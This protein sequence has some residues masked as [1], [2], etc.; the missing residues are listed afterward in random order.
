MR[1][2]T[3]TNRGNFLCIYYTGLKTYTQQEF[4]SSF[5]LVEYAPCWKCILQ[6]KLIQ[7]GYFI[8]L[9]SR[10]IFCESLEVDSNVSACGESSRVC[11][12]HWVRRVWL[13]VTP[14][15]VAPQAPL[16]VGFPR[17]EHWSGLLCLPLGIVPTP[18]SNLHLLTSAAMAGRFFITNATWEAQ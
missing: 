3:F 8:P 15:T 17:Q 2:M 10:D 5:Y 6:I 13:F 14:W 9:H 12:L 7:F 11:A 16:S 4:V 18:G 1:K